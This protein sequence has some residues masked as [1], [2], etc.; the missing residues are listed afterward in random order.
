[1]QRSDQTATLLHADQGAQALGTAPVWS[2]HKSR[3][4]Q[5]RLDS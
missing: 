3:F 5:G 4:G 2:G 1:M